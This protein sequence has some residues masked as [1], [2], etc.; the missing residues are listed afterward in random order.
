MNKDDNIENLKQAKI[1]YKRLITD[2]KSV[3]YAVE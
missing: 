2:S 1:L 3:F